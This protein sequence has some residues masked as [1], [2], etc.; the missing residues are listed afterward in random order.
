[1]LATTSLFFVFA[2]RLFQKEIWAFIASLILVLLSSLPW[3]E[4]N[5]PNG[6]LFVMGF[7]MLGAVLFSQ[8]SI[9][10]NLISQKID[11]KNSK[12]DFVFLFLAGNMMGL[13]VLT[14]VPAILDSAAFLAIFILIFTQIL[15]NNKS[16]QDALKQSFL[17][18]FKRGLAFGFGL[19]LPILLSIIYFISQGQGQDYLDY[20][21][22]YNLRYS[23]A[24]PL[25]LGNELLNFA[26]S[27]AGKTIILL[28]LFCLIVLNQDQLKKRFQFII[29]YFIFTLYSVLLSSRPYPHYF[30]QMVPAAALLL[31][32][33]LLML[34]NIGQTKQKQQKYNLLKNLIISLGL[35]ALTIYIMLT[36]NFRPYPTAAYYRRF[37]H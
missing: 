14:K 11:F 22:L 19:V 35:I 6:E 9:F 7:V 1:M 31:V 10:H 29:L 34:K 15:L 23:Q 32:E 26:F 18:L 4:G 8:S 36:L 13:A 25:D 16:R 21:L 17:Y 3:L 33:S 5:I 27:M 37:Y 2:K 24:W 20:G 12:R 30:I 28:I